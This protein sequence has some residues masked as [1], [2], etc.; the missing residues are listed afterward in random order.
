MSTR[1]S[2]TKLDEDILS[3]GAI[4]GFNLIA[5]LHSSGYGIAV[6]LLDS[7]DDYDVVFNDSRRNICVCVLLI[8]MGRQ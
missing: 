5:A 1:N 8:L 7:I 6:Y 2:H 3:R 4:E